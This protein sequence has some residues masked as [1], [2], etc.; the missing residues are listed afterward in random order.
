LL[1]LLLLPPHPL[2]LEGLCQF[3]V[4]QLVVLMLKF[5]LRVEQLVVLWCCLHLRAA[6]ALASRRG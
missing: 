5:G 2:L 6:A 1:H 3:L 4:D